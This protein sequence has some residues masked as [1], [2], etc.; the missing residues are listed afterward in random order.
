MNSDGSNL[1]QL[2]HYPEND[3]TAAWYSYHAGRPR[4]HPNENFISYQSK[5][6]GKSSLF[7]VTPDGKKQW[8]LT[9]IEHNEGWHDWSA[10]GKYLAIETY[11]LKQ[12]QFHITLMEWNSKTYNTL[13]RT[14]YRLQQAP[15][16]V[17]K[18]KK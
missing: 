8:K 4:W 17:R 2:T 10:D 9:G 5:Q 16:F 12:E 6:N 1:R 14:L 7:G 3:S 18:T 11:D 13:T 15:V